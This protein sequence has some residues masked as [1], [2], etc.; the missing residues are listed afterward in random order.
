MQL[1]DHF[2]GQRTASVEHLIHTIAAADEWNE[3]AWLETLL[4]HM[5]FD[6]LDW[7]G[8]IQGIVLLL[9]GLDQRDQDVETIP[10]GSVALRGHQSFDFL[11]GTTIAAMVSDWFYFHGV[12]LKSF[13]RRS[14]RTVGA[15]R[16]SGCTSHD[17]DS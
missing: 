14:C 16:R 8:K 10:L 7:I 15:C 17:R 3:I 12:C 4:V 5:E 11:E 2:Q 9:P 1:P 6:R 13:A